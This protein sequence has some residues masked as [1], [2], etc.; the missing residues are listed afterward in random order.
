MTDDL[1]QDGPHTAGRRV[2]ATGGGLSSPPGGHSMGL[3]KCSHNIVA[4]F[5][6]SNDPEESKGEATT[7]RNPMSSFPRCPLGFA[8]HSCPVWEEDG[9]QERAA[10]GT[11]EKPGAPTLERESQEKA[12]LQWVI[13]WPTFPSACRLVRGFHYQ[14]TEASPTRTPLCHLHIH[15]PSPPLSPGAQR[16]NPLIDS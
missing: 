10:T 2:L 15:Q 12:R 7:L 1:L 3:C 6:K 13:R 4:G 5:P 16:H 8:G 9:S 14:P 11:R